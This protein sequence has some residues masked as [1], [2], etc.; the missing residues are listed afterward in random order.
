MNNAV[1]R[2]TINQVLPHFDS[3]V[4]KSSVSPLGNGL[5]NDTFLV[6]NENHSF[7]LQRINDH[8]FKQPELVINNAMLIHQHLVAKR[9]AG[10]YS[11]TPIGQQISTA[12][13]PYAVVANNH[14]RAI[15]FIPDCYTVE[16]VSSPNQAQQVAASF[17][18]FTAALS[19]FPA[20]DLY[21]VIPK[22][23]DLSFRIE[24]LK[25]AASQDTQGRLYDCQSLVD[26]CLQQTTFINKV[27]KLVQILPTQVTH[28][29]TKINNLLFCSETAQPIA[30]IDLDTCMP[31]FIMNDFGDMVRTCCSN[32][33]EDGEDLESMSVRMDVFEAL[34]EGYVNAFSGNISDLELESLSVGAQLLPFMIGIRFLTDFLDGDL[35]FHTDHAMH[36]LM[37]AKNQLN[38]YRLLN[39]KEGELSLMVNNAASETSIC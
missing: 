35:Y 23:H 38:F 21:E 34:A 10:E 7:V 1:N 20:Q 26:F 30:V 29:D 8:V 15:Q 31:G 36:N 22:F 17:G 12:G 3:P 13:H 27:T 18:Q 19:D 25:Y 5:I 37:R 39:G 16:S 11:L 24:Q 2:Q 14:W 33:P 32:L 6:K 4:A 9:D 28:N